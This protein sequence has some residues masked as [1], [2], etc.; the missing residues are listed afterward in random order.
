MCVVC[1]ELAKGTL[2]SSEARRALREVALDPD[3]KSHV[4]E[5]VEELNRT[6]LEALKKQTPSS[7]KTQ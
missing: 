7:T 4:E 5:V 1:V 2:K 6:E 3:Q